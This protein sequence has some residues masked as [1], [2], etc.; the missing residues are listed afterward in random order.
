MTPFIIIIFTL[1]N[2]YQFNN[3]CLFN[4]AYRQNMQFLKFEIETNVIFAL[5]QFKL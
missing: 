5:S 2:V 3:A 1:V 4:R